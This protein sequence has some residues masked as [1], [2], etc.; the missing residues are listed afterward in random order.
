MYDKIFED[1][2]KLKK[3]LRWRLQVFERGI[4]LLHFK[5]GGVNSIIQGYF[6]F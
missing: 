5:P 1:D 4:Q 2:D 3:F 6:L